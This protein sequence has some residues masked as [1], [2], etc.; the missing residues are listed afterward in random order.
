MENVEIADRVQWKL[1]LRVSVTA[2]QVST[3]HTG[4]RSREAVSAWDHDGLRR[5]DNA[6]CML[7][8][9]HTGAST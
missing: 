4:Q 3:V 1:L 5:C 8:A 9:S 6:S 2:K 7:D